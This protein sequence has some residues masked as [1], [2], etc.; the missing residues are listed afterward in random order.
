MCAAVA[1]KLQSGDLRAAAAAIG[2]FP[3][4]INI[5]LIK[6]FTWHDISISFVLSC[7]VSAV[8]NRTENMPL[9]FLP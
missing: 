8:V 9:K 7:S 5:V 4:L 3:V 6:Q 2:N 1:R